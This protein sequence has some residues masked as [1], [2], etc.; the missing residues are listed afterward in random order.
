VGKETQ[1]DSIKQGLN[2]AI[3]HGKS[4]GRKT[5]GITLY[6]PHA[7]DVSRLFSE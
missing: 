4:K 1:L 5:E 6:Q 3:A 7:V 2:E